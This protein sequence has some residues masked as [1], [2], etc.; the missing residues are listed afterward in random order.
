MTNVTILCRV[1]TAAMTLTVTLTVTFTL[2][3]TATMKMFFK[4]SLT[5]STVISQQCTAQYQY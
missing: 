2:M 3:V 4:V 1:V 5:D